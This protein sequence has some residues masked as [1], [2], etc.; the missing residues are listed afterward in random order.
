MSISYDELAAQVNELKERLD[1]LTDPSVLEKVPQY[2]IDMQKKI[3]EIDERVHVIEEFQRGF[4]KVECR[5]DG[6]TYTQTFQTNTYISQLKQ[7]LVNQL[8]QE[9]P[10]D[11]SMKNLST[12]HIKY[13]GEEK[14]KTTIQKLFPTNTFGFQMISMTYQILSPDKTKIYATF[15]F[16]SYKPIDK[17]RAEISKQLHITTSSQN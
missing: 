6:K 16:P 7:F 8:K 15:S 12:N 5:C 11:E 14:D 3:N 13:L 9:N 17:V 10:Q 1:K 4:I 2:I